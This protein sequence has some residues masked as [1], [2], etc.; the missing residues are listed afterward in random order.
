[1]LTLDWLA[2]L[3]ATHRNAFQAK[4]NEFDIGGRDFHFDRH[5]CIMG[6]IN[7]SKDS[8]YRESVCF[9]TDQ[10]LRRADLLL[11][12]G[13]DVIDLGAES[14][15][16][17]ASL[18]GV[19]SQWKS[20]EP[21]VEKIVD[22]GGIVSLE[23]Y[24]LDLVK[25]ALESG[26]Q[27]INLTGHTNSKDVYRLCAQHQAAVIICY[28]QGANVRSVES[29]EFGS[30]PILEMGDWFKVEIDRA[31]E[32]GVKRIFL[33]PG[34][35]FYYRNMEDGASRVKHQMK[36]FLNTFRLRELGWPVC[37]ALPHS[38]ETFGEEVRTAESFFAILALLGKTDLLRTHEVSKVK[39]VIDTLQQF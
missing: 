12:Q 24:H 32:A 26:V 21:I 37:H 9:N 5:P 15:L 25:R 38:F 34:L 16:A 27:V 7:L 11:A 4:V 31:L 14:T 1:M 39:A 36:T 20:L 10:A 30:D 2:D 19:E 22:N 18:V 6:V 28:V 23:T 8:W 13:A 3:H 33:D 35:G 29:L 17:Q